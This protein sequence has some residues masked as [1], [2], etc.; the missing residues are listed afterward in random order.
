LLESCA[1]A[2]ILKKKK[3]IEFL[4]RKVESGTIYYFTCHYELSIL[5]A[6]KASFLESLIQIIQTKNILD[7]AFYKY[8]FTEKG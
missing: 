4:K 7:D 8:I 5:Q 1:L 6:S 2:P 3:K